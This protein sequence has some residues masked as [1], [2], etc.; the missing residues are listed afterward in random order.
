MM[1]ITKQNVCIGGITI[2][3]KINIM[4][5]VTCVLDKGAVLNLIGKDVAQAYCLSEVLKTTSRLLYSGSISPL[6][7]S[8]Q[9]TA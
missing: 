1:A 8:R 9:I 6:K 2:G 4:H 7:L 3:A 5:S